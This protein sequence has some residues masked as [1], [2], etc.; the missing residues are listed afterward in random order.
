MFTRCPGR[1]NMQV[2]LELLKCSNC[3]AEI[4]MFSSEIKVKCS[5]CGQIVYR[6]SVPTSARRNLLF[7]VPK[8]LGV[9]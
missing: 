7:A 8:P 6:D 9:S 2:R 3:S 4:E 5:Q 1:D